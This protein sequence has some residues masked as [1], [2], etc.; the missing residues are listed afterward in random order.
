MG[1][2]IM[3]FKKE[4]CLMICVAGLTAVLGMD[5][6]AG[7]ATP[8]TIIVLP[9]RRRIVELV[10]QVARVKDVG[11]VS[12]NAAPTLGAPLIHIWNGSEWIQISMDDY[13]SGSFMSGDPKHL[14]VLGDSATVPERMAVDPTWCHDVQRIPS[15][16]TATL[17]NEMN[18][19]L[20]FSSRQWKWLAA[21]NGLAL[22]DQNAE[23]RRYG[24]WGPPGNE[25]ESAPRTVGRPGDT[26]KMPPAPIA[27]AVKE[28]LKP[29]TKCEIKSE[30]VPEAKAESHP[31][32]V[33]VPATTVAEPAKE[34]VKPVPPAPSVPVAEKPEDPVIAPPVT[35]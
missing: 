34:E 12:Y 5:V 2:L 19:T 32:T 15:L 30:P 7:V 35:P 9:A 23:R 13:I 22:T 3:S 25:E 11:L 4:F 16:A 10:S 8:S 14:I 26:V 29:A 21:E 31:E 27:P 1:G 20:K 6:L 33:V 28:D 18:K 17:L 24:R